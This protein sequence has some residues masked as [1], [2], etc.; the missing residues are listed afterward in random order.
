VAG[1]PPG[2]TLTSPMLFVQRGGASVDLV[3]LEHLVGVRREYPKGAGPLR[4]LVPLP[5]IEQ[6]GCILMR[7]PG[8]E[9]VTQLK[10]GARH[11]RSSAVISR[12]HPGRHVPH[13]PEN[14]IDGNPTL[15]HYRILFSLRGSKWR[16][17]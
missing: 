14:G 7:V 9:Q 16:A 11:H 8:V 2:I 1:P 3:P 5:V 17:P 4:T 15:Y 10:R 6:G 12:E 13:A